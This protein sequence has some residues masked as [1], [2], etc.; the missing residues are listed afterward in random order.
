[1]P[2]ISTRT[3]V[4]RGDRAQRGAGVV[5]REDRLVAVP[6]LRVPQRSLLAHPHA[7]AVARARDHERRP[8]GTRCARRV[9]RSHARQ[10]A[11]NSDGVQRKGRAVRG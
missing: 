11:E 4:C 3:F 9:G 5:V 6:V 8:A 10:H 1:M 2:P 7:V